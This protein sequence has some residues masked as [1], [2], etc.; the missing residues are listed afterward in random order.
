MIKT[1]VKLPLS[2]SAEDIISAITERLPI[3]RDEILD[4]EILKRSLNVSDKKDIHKILLTC[5]VG[6]FYG[7]STDDLE[8]VTVDNA[9]S[10]PKWNMGAKITIDSSTLMNKGLEVIEAKWLFGVDIENIEVYIHRQSIVHS[11]VEF[12]DGSVIAQLGVPDMRLP[13]SY[14]INY[15][16]RGSLVCDVSCAAVRSQGRH[17]AAGAFPAV[18]GERF[19]ALAR[20]LPRQLQH[21]VDLLGRHDGEP[22]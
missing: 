20:R 13:I 3:K 10:H 22:A 18:D 2:Y 16:A 7:K 8:D 6:P 12:C 5:S 4:T 15:P 1:D 9:L 21:G 11:M 17:G 19:F 14:A